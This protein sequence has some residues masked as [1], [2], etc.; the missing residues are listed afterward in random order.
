MP[1]KHLT[2]TTTLFISL[3]ASSIAF[4][5][6]WIL[7]PETSSISFVST[8]K[9]NIGE[10]HYFQ[11]FS[12]GIDNEKATVSIDPASIQSGVEIRDS[13]MK[14]HLFKTRLYPTIE[15]SASSEELNSL[16]I[17]TP[18]SMTV[19]A[20][21][22]LHNVSNEITLD[23]LVTKHS[24]AMLSIVSQKPVIIRAEDYGMSEGVLKLAN[25]VG[26]IPITQAVPTFFS[27]NFQHR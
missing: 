14:E 27:L 5:H 12:G 26:D 3:I 22:S 24:N 9:G 11:T 21:L 25:L 1:I 23:M 19:S 7:M 15:I 10:A 16:K 18:V 8:K 6:N 4:S 13:R 2:K 17:D 20:T